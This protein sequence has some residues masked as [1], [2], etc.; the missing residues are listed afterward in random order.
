MKFKLFFLHTSVKM[1]LGQWLVVAL[2][3][4]VAVLSNAD[5]D[6]SDWID[7]NDMLNFDHS[8]GTMR[9]DRKVF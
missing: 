4:G 7:P 6:R 9:K 1:K 8:S 5:V 2:I 3:A